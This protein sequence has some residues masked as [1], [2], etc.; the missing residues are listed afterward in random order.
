MAW[1]L[2]DIKPTIG[3]CTWNNRRIGL[4]HIATRLDRFL[5]QDT[6][7]LLGLNMTSKI[8]PFG[9]LDHNPI[10]LEIVND[11]NLGPVPF[12]FNPMWANHAEFLKIIADSWDPLVTG[13][14]VFVLKEKLRRLK[15]SLKS[16]AKEIP[17]PNFTK[18]QAALALESH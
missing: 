7:L 3:K 11:K 4:G 15:K 2:I 13:S 16:W 14:P 18:I 6:F 12:R 5:V 9:G 10:L 17:K 1:D 8:L